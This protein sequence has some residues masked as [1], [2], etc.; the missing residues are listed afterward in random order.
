M[1]TEAKNKKILYLK[2]QKENPTGN[3][4][5]YLV[6]IYQYIYNDSKDSGKGWSDASPWKM[7]NFVYNGNPDHMGVELIKRWKKD[8]KELGY[9]RIVKEN[10]EWKT[11]IDKELDF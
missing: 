11:Y 8:L 2:N 10:D 3:Y 9:I 1:D 6:R 5:N 4:R 7:L